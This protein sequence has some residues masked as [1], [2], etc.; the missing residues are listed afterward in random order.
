MEKSQSEQA[1]VSGLHAECWGAFQKV[2]AE[3]APA[4][5][6]SLP[7]SQPALPTV[8]TVCPEAGLFV[9]PKMQPPSESQVTCLRQIVVAGLG[10]HLARRV[11]SEDL[12]DDKWKNAYKV[13]LGGGRRVAAPGPPPRPPLGSPP[14]RIGVGLSWAPVFLWAPV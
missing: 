2:R 12:P 4:S 8:N 7:S 11:Q 10:D 13:S 1:A 3:A 6:S 9:D 5:L 14:P